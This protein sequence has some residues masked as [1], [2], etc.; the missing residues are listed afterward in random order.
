VKEKINCRWPG[1]FS[2]I[3]FS[4]PW[5]ELLTA[6]SL[7]YTAIDKIAYRMANTLQAGQYKS[8]LLAVAQLI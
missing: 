1:F 2:F 6:L 8:A 4:Y 3:P 7:F 5:G